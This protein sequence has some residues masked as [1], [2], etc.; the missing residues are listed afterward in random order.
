MQ[1]N[2]QRSHTLVYLIIAMARYIFVGMFET[3][4]RESLEAGGRGKELLL[5]FGPS[6]FASS[7]GAE[8]TPHV[9]RKYIW[10]DVR[11]GRDMDF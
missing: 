3:F 6:T 1:L 10:R 11:V 4:V 8:N 2:N 9:R 7:P 5:K